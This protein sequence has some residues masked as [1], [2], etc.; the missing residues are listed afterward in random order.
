MGIGMIFCR[1]MW[2]LIRLI[3]EFGE[4]GLGSMRKLDAFL[5]FFLS[6]CLC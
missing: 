3:F 5:F 2:G 1:G 6:L 4:A